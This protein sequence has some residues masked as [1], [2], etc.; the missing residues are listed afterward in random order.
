MDGSL[1]HCTGDSDR[2]HSQGKEMQ[3]HKMVIRGGLTDSCERRQ[4]KSKGEKGRYTH[5]NSE[6]QR[7]A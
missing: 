3:K 4:V 2:D 6:F 1:Q 5:L 7:I